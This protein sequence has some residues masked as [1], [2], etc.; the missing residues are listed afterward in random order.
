VALMCHKLHYMR[1]NIIIS[2]CSITLCMKLIRCFLT[3][4]FFIL[5]ILNRYINSKIMTHIIKDLSYEF[6]HSQ[7]PKMRYSI[8]AWSIF[9]LW[10]AFHSSPSITCQTCIFKN[11]SKYKN[12]I[13]LKD[14]H[15]IRHIFRKLNLSLSL[16]NCTFT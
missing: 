7:L 13:S 14:Y 2:I 1:S 5:L 4:L 12:K 9:K 8:I 15:M 6:L 16:A 10:R 11:P 3:A